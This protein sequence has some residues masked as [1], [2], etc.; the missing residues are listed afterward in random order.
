MKM[1]STIENKK[2]IVSPDSDIEGLS[3]LIFVIFAC[4]VLVP[5]VQVTMVFYKKSYG[6]I[7]IYGFPAFL[8]L[9]I[10]L[11]Q[12]YFIF[13]TL[14]KNKVMIDKTTQEILLLKPI[15]FFNK[16]ISFSNPKSVMIILKRY[17]ENKVEKENYE[18]YI[19]EKNGNLL[20]TYVR[21][22][23][24]EDSLVIAKDISQFLNIPL[25]RKIELKFP[26]FF[27]ID[28]IRLKKERLESLEELRP[29]IDREESL[30]INEYA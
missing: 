14:F 1:K 19:E 2:L 8:C 27:V 23:E 6:D 11:I 4:I 16:S 28:E 18:I 24:F 29:I 7:Y 15:G 22:I 10:V 9:V 26:R 21:N 25:S 5:F 30:N 3:G 17:F 13:I 20:R 12:I